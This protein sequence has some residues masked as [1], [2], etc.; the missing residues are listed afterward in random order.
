MSFCRRRGLRCQL[1]QA[2]QASTAKRPCLH[3]RLCGT[4]SFKIAQIYEETGGT[5]DVHPERPR[6]LPHDRITEVAS[7]SVLY[8]PG[9]REATSEVDAHAPLLAFEMPVG[10]PMPPWVYAARRT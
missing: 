8:R 6:P 4:N 2:Q 5:A 3:G 7:V 10:H 1:C 9:R